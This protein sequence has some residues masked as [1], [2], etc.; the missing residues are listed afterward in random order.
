MFEQ[1]L[2][3]VGNSLA[4]SALGVLVDLG[5]VHV[6]GVETTRSDLA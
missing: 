4:L 1:D 2:N 3:P 6:A 5:T